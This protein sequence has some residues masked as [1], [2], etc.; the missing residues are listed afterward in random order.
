VQATAQPV[1]RLRQLHCMCADQVTNTYTHMACRRG[2]TA[3]HMACR[4]GQHNMVRALA[5]T[6]DDINVPGVRGRTPLHEAVLG[7]SREAVL[8]LCEVR[9]RLTTYAYCSCV[10]PVLLLYE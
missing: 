6:V 8:F 3:L 10:V 9:V 7:G 1:C 2:D 5:L 4:T